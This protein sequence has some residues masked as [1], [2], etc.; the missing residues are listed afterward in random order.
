MP[1]WTEPRVWHRSLL[2]RSRCTTSIEAAGRAAPVGLSHRPPPDERTP[3]LQAAVNDLRPDGGESTGDA[4][5]SV[6]HRDS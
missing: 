6:D 3:T 5:I 4:A 1:C 2:M